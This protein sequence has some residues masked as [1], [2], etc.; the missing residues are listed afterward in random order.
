MT[1]CSVTTN[2]TQCTM[3]LVRVN[4]ADSFRKG[5]QIAH[6]EINDSMPHRHIF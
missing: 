1:R 6:G 5:R 3:S 4:P 2:N